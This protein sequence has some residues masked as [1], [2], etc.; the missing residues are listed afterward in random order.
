MRKP[1]NERLIRRRFERNQNMGRPQVVILGRRP[2]DF[3]LGRDVIRPSYLGNLRTL[4][5]QVPS[6]YIGQYYRSFW[7]VI[8]PRG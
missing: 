1:F 5:R 4:V 6:C 3:T 8:L 7:D 2:Q